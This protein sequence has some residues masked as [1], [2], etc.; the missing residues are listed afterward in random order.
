MVSLA[1]LWLPILA[2][3]VLVFFASAIFHMVLKFWHRPDCSGFSNED[4]VRVAI[5]AGSSGAGMYMLPY[6]KPEDMKKEE[7]QRK[8]NEGPVGFVFLRPTGNMN[9]AAPLGQWFLFCLLVSLFAGYVAAST[10]AP[11]TTPAQVFR[12]VGTAALLGHAFSALPT[13]IWWGHPWRSVIKHLVDGIVYAL[14]VGASFAW[15]WPK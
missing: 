8:F 3:A 1:Q 14:I 15:L 6:C 2:S 11:G 4:D 13:G 9:M 5:R 10:L 12:V 7:T